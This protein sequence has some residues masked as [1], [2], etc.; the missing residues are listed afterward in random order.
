MSR[1]LSR[2]TVEHLRNAATA[3]PQ[4]PGEED[5]PWEFINA[6]CN[7][8]DILQARLDAVTGKL[9]ELAAN[10]ES[11]ERKAWPRFTMAGVYSAVRAALAAAEGPEP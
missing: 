7:S 5:G 11:A 1:L 9:R 10:V 8:H 3:L 6:L 4:E 2:E